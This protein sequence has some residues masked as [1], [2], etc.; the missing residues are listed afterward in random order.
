MDDKKNG[1][2]VQYFLGCS[3]AILNFA[4]FFETMLEM[5]ITMV[6]CYLYESYIPSL[7]L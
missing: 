5:K 7:N 4:S 2:S 6:S 3:G 1:Q